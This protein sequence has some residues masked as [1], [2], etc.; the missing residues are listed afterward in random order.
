VAVDGDGQVIGGVRADDVLA[1]LD[2]QRQEG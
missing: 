2:R 1:A